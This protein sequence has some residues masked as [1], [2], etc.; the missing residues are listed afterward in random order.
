MARSPSSRICGWNSV[1]SKRVIDLAVFC[2]WSMASSSAVVRSRMSLRSNGVMKVRRMAR[3]TARVTSSAASSWATIAAQAAATP[4]P[5]FSRSRSASAP[6][7]NSRACASNWSKKL[8]SR[9]NSA[10]NQ[11]IGSPDQGE[12]PRA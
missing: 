4:A 2:I 7:T 5:P 12:S 9:G 1:T 6:F 3:K 11:R 10:W 8:S